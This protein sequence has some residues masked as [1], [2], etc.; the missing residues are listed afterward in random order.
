MAALVLA[1]KQI[2]GRVRSCA[3]AVKMAD[4]KYYSLSSSF[5]KVFFFVFTVC[6]TRQCW[7]LLSFFSEL[8]KYLESQEL[9]DDELKLGGEQR[10]G[11]SGRGE[12]DSSA[13][14]HK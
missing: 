4:L 8:M 3:T 2:W 10:E 13:F 6:R 12:V 5:L 7:T 11:I 9:A 1:C 14:G